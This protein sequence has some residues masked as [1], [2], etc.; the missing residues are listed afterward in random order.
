MS[1]KPTYEELEQRNKELEKK[2]YKA[3]VFLPKPFLMAFRKLI[4]QELLLL[5]MMH[6]IV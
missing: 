2:A 5:L 1:K 6:T 4:H 3:I